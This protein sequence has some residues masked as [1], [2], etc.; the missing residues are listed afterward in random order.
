MSDLHLR[1][2]LVAFRD[3]GPDFLDRSKKRLADLFP[4]LYFSFVDGEADLLFF[5]SGGSEREALHS[6]ASTEREFF[7]L[8]LQTFL[9]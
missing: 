6:F 2:K 7:M 9:Y 3:A 4:G 8:I 5:A 1:V